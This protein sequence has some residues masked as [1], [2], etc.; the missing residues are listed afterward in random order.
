MEKK[1]K[2]MYF[3]PEK[4]GTFIEEHKGAENKAETNKVG[5]S[6]V[7]DSSAVANKVVANKVE[8]S[9]M[10]D[11]RSEDNRPERSTVKFAANLLTNEDCGVILYD[12]KGAQKR[13]PFHEKGKRGTLYGLELQGEGITDRTYNFYEGNQIITDPYAKEVHGLEKWGAGR[14]R[15]RKTYGVLSWQ[16]FDW[17]DDKPLMIPLE[18]SIFY[19]LN[20]RAFTMHKSS[21]VKDRGTFEGIV[22]KIPYLKELGITAVELMPCYEYDECMIEDRKGEMPE[23]QDNAGINTSLSL[24]PEDS[25]ETAFSDVFLKQTA[26]K[27]GDRHEAVRLN[28]WGF[29]KGFYFSPKAAYSAV[30]SPVISF[31]NMVRELHKNGIEVIVQFYFPEG[32]RQLYMLDVVKHWVLEYHIDGVRINGFGIPVRLLAEEPVLKNTK[33]WCESYRDE[34]LPY[35]TNPVFKNFIANNGNFRNDMRR[36]LKGD[37]NLMNQVVYYKRRN[38][39]AYGVVNYMADYD[40]FSLYDSVS[41]GNKH[42]EANGEDNRD[43]TNDNFSWN[44]GVEGHTRR[45]AVLSLRQTQI[46]N[47]LSFVL[48]S[49]GI[50][51]IFSGDEFGA[52]R[53]GNN[54]CYCQDN[55]TGWINWK[56]NSFANEILAYV[57]FLV[58]LRRKHPILHMKDELKIMDYKGCGFPDLSYHGTEAWRPD[59]S[60]ISQVI[61]IVLCGQYAPGQEDDSFY[62]ACNMHWTPHKLA[63]PK[64]G[65]DK[66]WT[67]IADTTFVWGQDVDEHNHIQD[68]S[69]ITINGR[70]IAIFKTEKI[71]VQRGGPKRTPV[72]GR[73]QKK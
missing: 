16:D 63:L 36:F 62:I 64:L 6:K 8:T 3:Q 22:E 61:G 48:L 37:A 42:N 71:I 12:R 69:I 51:F 65:K 67:K 44:C 66:S 40:G 45:K 13:F 4:P 27:A 24:H 38:P 58:H 57:R 28:C 30:G 17:Q 41:Y 68:S 43:G 54:N 7:V 14:T 39:A 26:V 72:R 49:Q 9:I 60:Y 31:K 59:F 23:G 32:I 50:P 34:D 56:K 47:A 53:N 52:T 25:D 33:I 1:W 35:I 5:K 2:V 21:G 11:A 15:K 70:N 19:G 46:K 29:Q 20:V 55:E 73:R 10:E 18:D